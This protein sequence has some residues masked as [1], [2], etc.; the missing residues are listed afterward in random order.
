VKTEVAVGGRLSG[1]GVVCSW[2]LV[3]CWSSSIGFAATNDVFPGDYYPSNPG[4]KVLSLYAFHRVSEGPYVRG[5]KSEDSEISGQIVALRGVS[6]FQLFGMTASAVAVLS[7][8]DLAA[9]PAAL[10][11]AIG[12]RTAGLGD[13]RLG[14]TVWPINDREGANYLGLSAMVIAPTGSY[15]RRQPLNYA[16]N[17]W[18]LVLSGGWQKDITPRWLVELSPELTLYGDNHDYVDGNRLAQDPA[19][20]LTGYL[21]WRTKPSFHLFLGGQLNRG[22]ETRINNLALDNPPENARVNVGATWFLPGKQQLILRLNREIRVENG[23]RIDS[24]VALRY[25][26]VF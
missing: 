6:A 18:R 26:K 8:A 2:L 9:S 13:L 12:R 22:G 14:L 17:R 4:D 19:L 15:D 23:F 16:E 25:Q 20:A 10:G 24:G 3:W 21:R 11:S 1:L 7:G 5:R